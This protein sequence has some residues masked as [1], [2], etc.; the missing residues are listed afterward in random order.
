MALLTDDDVFGAPSASLL[1]DSDVFGEAS[2]KPKQ[3][4]GIAG[5]IGTALKRGVLQI[6]GMATG[7]ADIAAAPVSIATGVNRPVSRAADWIGE[8]TG[9][10]PGKWAEDANAEYSPAM[11]QA[12]QNVEQAKGFLPTI[13]AV[14]QNP[15]V[16]AQVVAE[17]LPSTIAGGLLAR[18]AMGAVAGAEKL[19]ALRAAAGSADAA[20]AN[21]ARRELLKSGAIAAGIGEGAITA[22]QQMAQTGYDVDPAL[23]A[24]TALGAG[25]GTGVI[26]GLSGRVAGSALGRRLGLS[27]IET[28][29]AAGTLGENASKAGIAGAV[30]RIG[31]GVVQEGLLEEAPQS[32]QEQVWQNIAAGKPWSE[33]AA[34]AAALGAVAGGVMG[35]AVNAIP[36]SAQPAEQPPAVQPIAQE[37]A[38]AARIPDPQV[39]PVA[40]I[41]H[42]ASGAIVKATAEGVLSGAIPPNTPATP[43]TPAAPPTAAV[44]APPP[45]GLVAG[46]PIT[47]TT[48]AAPGADAPVSTAATSLTTNQVEPAGVPTTGPTADASNQAQ[49]AVPPAQGS[50]AQPATGAVAGEVRQGKGSASATADGQSATIRDFR[51]AADCRADAG[52][53]VWREGE[54]C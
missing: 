10:Q 53:E 50:E 13:G 42:P 31:A 35:G 39:D 28:S 30:K 5:D 11:Q 9:F 22:G 49:I 26:G 7:L 24:G 51:I 8:Q 47:E 16:A 3:N 18:G 37:L 27:D 29:M 52:R 45:Q 33:G 17:S 41:N 21:A 44:V 34:E 15:R 23:A 54:G 36:R 2:P 48:P 38:A 4:T 46:V 32:Y 1:S 12:Q 14:V 20:V 6:P 25:I 43:A 40:A 19:T